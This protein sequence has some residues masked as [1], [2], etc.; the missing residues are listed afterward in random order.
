MGVVSREDANSNLRSLPPSPHRTWIV[1]KVGGW[2][3]RADGQ[4]SVTRRVPRLTIWL[5]VA[6]TASDPAADNRMWWKCCRKMVA[7]MASI[8]APV[9][10]RTIR[11]TAED[12]DAAGK[13]VK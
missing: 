5:P 13:K 2:S 7:G 9:S 8:S 3:G 4:E 10:G 1:D 11:E 12:V 6:V